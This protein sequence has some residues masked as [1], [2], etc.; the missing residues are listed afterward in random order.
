MAYAIIPQMRKL[1]ISFIIPAKDED[2]SVLPLYKEI[3]QNVGKLKKSFEIIFIDDGSRD[4]TLEKLIQLRKKDKR[5]RVIQLRG[6]FGK[7]VALQVGFSHAKGEIIFTLDADLQD[8]PIEIPRFLKKM[9]EGYDLVSGWKKER[10]D[11]KVSKVIPS[12]IINFLARRFTQV[13]IHDM[14]CG[15]KAYRREVVQNLNLYGELYRFIPIMAAKMRFKVTEIPI[16]HRQRKFGKSKFGWNRSIKGVLDLLT[17]IFLTGYGQR[18]A[19]FFGTIG[20]LFFGIGFVIGL[21]ITY[22]RV[23]TGSIQFRQPLLFLGVLLMVMGVQLVTTGLLA[24]MIVYS[25][26]KNDYSSVIKKI[27]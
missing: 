22:L 11:P 7:S 8:D 20:C 2:A 17:I 21:Y 9:N 25:R 27:T 14:N 19:H 24:E 15:Y 12:R 1:D 5:V 10:H 26:T 16:K 18:P 3:T 13:Q 4:K 23:T 6:N